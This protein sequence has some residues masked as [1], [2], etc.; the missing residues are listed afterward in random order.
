ML[1]PQ[2]VRKACA[3]RN[4][5]QCWPHQV[6]LPHILPEYFSKDHASLRFSEPK[7]KQRQISFNALECIIKS[8]DL[9]LQGKKNQNS[10]TQKAL[11]LFMFS[12]LG[13]LTDKTRK[14]HIWYV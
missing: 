9:S 12:N 13:S 1:A 5:G 4:S 7:E 3:P 11:G 2:L 6:R 8:M 10:L 14:F